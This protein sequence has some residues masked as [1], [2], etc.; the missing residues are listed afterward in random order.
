MIYLF[1]IS[2][3]CVFIF[4]L[5][6]IAYMVPS[7]SPYLTVDKKYPGV[8]SVNISIYPIEEEYHNG[9]LLGY[10]ILYETSCYGIPKSSGRAA[11]ANEMNKKY[12]H[13]YQYQRSFFFSASHAKNFSQAQIKLGSL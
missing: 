13:M 4:L 11:R 2:Y 5:L 3:C 6:F 7:R 9:K 12:K 10:T 8:D 1:F